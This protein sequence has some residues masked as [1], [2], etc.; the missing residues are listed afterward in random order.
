MVC[1]QFFEAVL[2]ARCGQQAL[3]GSYR[4]V[5][6]QHPYEDRRM[7][8]EFPGHEVDCVLHVGLKAGGQV[9]CI[10]PVIVA[11]TGRILYILSLLLRGEPAIT[12]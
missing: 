4:S 6:A 9:I 12:T 7:V 3:S 1:E 2:I 5:V 11:W 10:H 8:V